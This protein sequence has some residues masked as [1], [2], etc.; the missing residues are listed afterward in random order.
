MLGVMLVSPTLVSG[1]M[2][3]LS[4]FDANLLRDLVTRRID[5]GHLIQ[6]FH[7]PDVL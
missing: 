2:L 1:R 6:T 7:D 5:L 4:V 3:K